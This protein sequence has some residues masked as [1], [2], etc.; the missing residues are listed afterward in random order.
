MAATTTN[1]STSIEGFETRLR[2]HSKVFDGLL[3]LIPP[4]YYIPEDHETK[5][6]R[7]MK[8]TQKENKNA[9]KE[10]AKK[11][12]KLKFDI[13]NE[14][15]VKN[16][17]AKEAQK[18]AKAAKKSSITENINNSDDDDDDAMEVEE[19]TTVDTAQT[20]DIKA[21][22]P[23]ASIDKLRSKLEARI[24]SL[25]QKR[26]APEDPKSREAIL[27]NRLNRKRAKKEKKKK[28]GPSTATAAPETVISNSNPAST[29]KSPN[30][31][32]S[33]AKSADSITEAIS[34][35]TV[36]LGDSSSQSKKKGTM[37]TK[38]AIQKVEQ[39][40]KQ[41]EELRAANEGDKA[42]K[43]AQKDKWHGALDKARG[44]KVKDDL[45]KLKQTLRREQS[46]KS[47]SKTEWRDRTD[48][49]NKQQMDRQKKRNDN[50]KAR[51]EGKSTKKGGSAK[52][53]NNKKKAR[54]GFEGKK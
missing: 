46:Q 9:K 42:Y 23:S 10:A 50:L 37:T 35:G 54:P 26:K 8:H 39:R 5:S 22:P 15:G 19:D 25:R 1:L 49:V 48:T 40:Q 24:Q 7:F 43:E 20:E 51:A 47:K 31:V 21:L 17:Q 13:E 36:E 44:I 27:Q 34:F 45:K 16:I 12:Y 28:K 2:Q 4:K 3:K 29:K 41:L 53:K 52:P 38:Q 6:K 11:A 32:A 14:E 33:D 30:G 18:E